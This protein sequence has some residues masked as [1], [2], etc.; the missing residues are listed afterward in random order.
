MNAIV[1]HRPRDVERFELMQR[2][3]RMF[4]ISP[5]VPAHLRQGGEQ[6]AL[7][8]CFIALG[9]ARAMG[10]NPIMVLQNIHIINGR[11]G[12]SSQYMIARANASG[13]FKGRIGWAVTGAGASLSVTAFAT[14]AETGQRVEVAVDM[15]MA[16]AEG[17]T[18]NPKYKSM[19][20]VM[21]R[22]RA[23]AFLVRFYAPEVMMGY[24]TAEEV[25]DL[26][27][28]GAD[29]A[30]LAQ[31]L[32]AQ[33]IHAQF[34]ASS[35][36]DAEIAEV[37]EAASEADVDVEAGVPDAGE[38]P[39]TE[40]VAEDVP[41]DDEQYPF[42]VNEIT[43]AFAMAQSQDELTG[44]LGEYGLMEGRKWRLGAY[45]AEDARMI[46]EAYRG[47]LNGMRRVAEQPPPTQDDGLSDFHE[48]PI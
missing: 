41:G 45:R 12:W 39:H 1:E 15:E 2:E 30:P 48:S 36:L 43:G 27:Q 46:V 4:S 42:D 13:V 24:H 5:L 10:E 18:K 40:S 11:A 16:S 44:L 29:I 19:P 6:A 3:A 9:M 21:L 23:A 37:V 33:A 38:P 31:T 17:W 8:N 20:E 22:Y 7:A 34:E 25:E 35:G 28:A 32:S 26:A 47:A 14:L